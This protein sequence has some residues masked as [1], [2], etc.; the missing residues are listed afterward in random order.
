[1]SEKAENTTTSPTWFT[2][3]RKIFLTVCCGSALVLAAILIPIAVFVIAPKIAQ[4]SIDQSSLSFTT[5][6]ISS[7]QETA[8]TLNSNGQ[9]TNAGSLD[10]TISFPNAVSVYWTDR[11]NNAADLLIGY[12]NLPDLAVSGSSHA[13]DVKVQNA[14]FK[15]ADVKNMGQFSKYLISSKS[16]SWL[17]SGSA[18]AKALGIDI[19]NLSMNKKVVVGGFAGFTGVTID[20]FDLPESDPTKGIVIQTKTTLQNPSIITIELGQLNFDTYV[21]GSNIGSLTAEKVT[22]AP[23]KNSLDLNGHLKAINASDV[24][25]LSSVFSFYLGGTS[26]PLIVNGTSVVPAAG[27]ASWLSAGFVGLTLDV[28]LNGESEEQ[29]K[30]RLVSNL[31]IPAISV[32]FNPADSTGFTVNSSAPVINTDF[33]SP[34]NFPL[35][36]QSAQQDIYFVDPATNIKFAHLTTGFN[37]ASADQTA[38]KLNTSFTD[39]TMTT[40]DNST[41]AQAAYEAFFTALTLAP[42]YTFNVEGLVTAK[43][44]TAGGLVTISNVNLTDSLTFAGFDGLSNVTVGAVKVVGGDANGLQL[45]IDTT[46]LNPSQITLNLNAD[47]VMNM[48]ASTGEILGTVTLPNLSLAPG[49]NK[50]AATSVFNPKGD[51]AVAAGKILLS[52][53]L[54]QQSQKVSIAGGADAVKYT[55]LKQAFSKV[56]VNTDLPSSITQNLVAGAVLSTIDLSKTPAQA[57]TLLNLVNPLDTA[58]AVTNMEA[59]VK[60]R[61]QQ[62]GSIKQDLSGNP[63]VVPAKTTAMSHG[64]SMDLDVSLVSIVALLKGLGGDLQVDITSTLGTAV[65]AGS[66]YGASIDY[67]QSNV[68]T[69]VGA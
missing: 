58:F 34:F 5:V 29:R 31:K 9:V 41:E 27:P 1:M 67:K 22:L 57:T 59:S 19:N 46:I 60:Y 68:A 12:L 44:N 66:G 40:V 6:S 43:A 36:V 7:I 38:G 42:G 14:Q 55:S 49:P 32:T 37:P 54:A 35:N 25:T 48:A 13:A 51:A 50:I 16:F 63:I 3:K 8:F 21:N 26:N 53:F 20:A 33:Y 52:K 18:K 23:G 61:G 47:V 28:T 39:A 2:R 11:P 65:G 69:T 45:N 62:I 17:L 24:D 10:A 15:I 30:H 64:V 56:T 4:Q